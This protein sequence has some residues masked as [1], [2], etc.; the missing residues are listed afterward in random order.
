VVVPFHGGHG[1]CYPIPSFVEEHKR[2]LRATCAIY[3]PRPQ[4][5]E[6]DGHWSIPPGPVP[7]EVF[8]HLEHLRKHA[9][10]ADLRPLFAGSRE[11]VSIQP[12]YDEKVDR[13]V[14]GRLALAG[15]AATLARPHTGSGATT[16]M[17]DVRCLEQLGEKHRG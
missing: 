3:A 13:Y 1:V 6:V 10:P 12:I 11:E 9:I 15:D 2:G 17:Q 4:E 16:A 8:A 14:D 7:P 5:L